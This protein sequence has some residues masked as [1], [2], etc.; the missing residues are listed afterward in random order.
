MTA[1][2]EDKHETSEERRN[3][4]RKKKKNKV[5]KRQHLFETIAAAATAA[6][7]HL[8]KVSVLCVLLCRTMSRECEFCGTNTHRT[9]N[10]LT[11]AVHVQYE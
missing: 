2:S 4:K 7:K 3:E 10:T 1:A 8:L 11:H 9:P 5:E 6:N